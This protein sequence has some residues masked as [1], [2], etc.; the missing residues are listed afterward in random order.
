MSLV[1]SLVSFFSDP[2]ADTKERAPEGVCGNCWG[3]Y[4]YDGETRQAMRDRQI[5]VQ[6]GRAQRAFIQEF[7]VERVDGIRLKGEG[8]AAKCERCGK[9][10]HGA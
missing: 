6:N 7:V 10:A 9:L 8:K 3:R 1:D 4:E 5:D 2:P